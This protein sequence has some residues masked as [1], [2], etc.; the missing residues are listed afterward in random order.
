MGRRK[1]TILD[2]LMVLPWWC[3]PVAAAVAYI[4]IGY[5]LP[6]LVPQDNP[7]FVAFKTA[8]P[9]I[10]PIAA[11]VLLV[12]MPFAYLNGRKKK[13]LV[14]TNRDL[15]SIRAM[16]WRDF[17]QLVA[18]AYRRKGYTVRENLTAGP[19]GGVDVILEKDGQLHLIQC[20]QWKTQKVGVKIVREMFGVM[21]AQNA[22]SAAIITS[23]MFTQEAR[24]FADGKA[25]D[26][27]DGARLNRMVLSVQKRPAGLQ[28]AT[29]ASTPMQTKVCPRCGSGLLERVARRGS[30]AGRSFLGCSGFPQCRYTQDA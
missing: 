2:D 29:A 6:A 9:Q 3:S 21:T 16:S 4:G 20:K 19:D 7:A 12:P 1:T 25:V 28:G 30:N 5:L 27:I 15:D 14:D 17:E 23:G 24:S 18:E 26:L 8:M 22:A 10:A 13:R 11:M